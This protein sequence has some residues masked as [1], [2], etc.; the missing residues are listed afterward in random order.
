MVVQK[1]AQRQ[2]RTLQAAAI[3]TYLAVAGTVLYRPSTPGGSFTG[4][5]HLTLTAEL[6]K[7]LGRTAV[8]V[9]L[10]R[11][12]AAADAV[13]PACLSKLLTMKELSGFR[14]TAREPA[15]CRSSVGFLYGVDGNF[16]GSELT[17]E[18][19]LTVPVLAASKEGHTKERKVATLLAKAPTPLLRWVVKATV[20]RE[21]QDVRSYAAAVRAH[22]AESPTKVPG[23]QRR[24]SA[25][26][27]SILP[28]VSPFTTSPPLLHSMSRPRTRGTPSSPTCS[29]HCAWFATDCPWNNR[30]ELCVLQRSTGCRLPSCSTKSPAAGA[31]VPHHHRDAPQDSHSLLAAVVDVA[32]APS[33]M[34]SFLLTASIPAYIFTVLFISPSP[35]LYKAL[36]RVA[37]EADIK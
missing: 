35:F 27:R 5:P 19:E 29:Q 12:I 34:R 24:I 9:K 31:E 32:V 26:R 15:D 18:L 30:C 4:S 11:N 8:C 20:R 14:V 10:H 1:A 21:Y 37:H 6:A 23:L 22:L 17:T 28:L 33:S 3:A 16:T 36:R 25:P 13:S 2:A 7:R